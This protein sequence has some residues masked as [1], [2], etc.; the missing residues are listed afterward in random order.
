MRFAPATSLALFIL[1]GCSVLVSSTEDRVRCQAGA[2]DP[3]PSG[4]RCVEGFCTSIPDGGPVCAE[5]EIGCNG[6]DDD[7]D[8]MIDE[9]SDFD[10][11]GFTWCDDDPAARD[12]RDDDP[13][14]YPGAP[15]DP[16]CDGADNDCSGA[17]AECSLGELCHP[18][19][20]CARPDCSF[21]NGLCDPATQRCNLATQPPSCETLTTANCTTNA[22]CATAAGTIC[23]PVSRTCIAPRAP[24]EECTDDAQCDGFDTG[25]RCFETAAL[26]LRP[27]DVGMAAKVCSRACCTNNDCPTGNVCWAPGTGARGC[28]PTSLIGA[29]AQRPCGRD[30]QCAPQD[31]VLR[32]APAYGATSRYAYVCG[33]EDFAFL[34]L[35]DLCAYDWNCASG[36][37]FDGFCSGACGGNADCP[38]SDYC[39]YLR[40]DARDVIQTCINV[41][42]NS[43]GAQGA[44]CT[45]GAQCQGA[46]C[47]SG[48]AGN[49]CADACCT[50]ADCA[51]GYVC[52][53]ADRATYWAML[54]Q[55]R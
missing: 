8:G 36:L 13:A 2:V 41:G 52:R 54:C 24:G 7:C 1:A 45:S 38:S 17:P 53:P 10:G 21:V 47:L 5:R 29:L 48:A 33:A 44:P 4:Q 55:E 18:G 23:D 15:S 42:A 34:G 31:C 39:G 11:D 22:D 32:D 35:G 19:G 14:I 43:G 40:I 9:G 30:D 46:A 37:C 25:A 26:G 28:V 20:G 50:D 49:Y 12:C 6:V 3:C 27:P 51:G 16:P